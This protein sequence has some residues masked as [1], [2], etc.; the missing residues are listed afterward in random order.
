MA[1]RYKSHQANR[2]IM[3]LSVDGQVLGGSLNQ[4]VSPAGFRE[5]GFGTLRFATAGNHTVRLAMVGRDATAG[6]YTITADVFTLRPDNT[7]PVISASCSN[8]KKE[9]TG[10]DGAVVTFAATA[11]DDLDGSV[12]VTF[13]PPSGSL[14]ALGGT[15]IVGT[16]RDFMGNTAT[17]NCEVIVV[18]T[19][20]PTLTLSGNLI[21]E[22]TSSA[23]AAVT[24]AASAH[25]IV[26]GNVDVGL[27]HQSG[28][29]FPL[30]VT[31]V[32]A[33]AQD[34]FDNVATGSFTVTVVDTTPPTIHVP[35]PITVEATSAAGAAVTFVASA[36]DVVSG[37]VPVSYSIN[38]GSTFPLG[39]TIVTATATDA[40]GNTATG[41]FMVTV[42][43]STA[44]VIE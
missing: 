16:A 23:G 42:V 9:A 22:A 34:D 43:D 17:V 27:S 11:T 2:G 41:T 6:A 44:P 18:D 14:F 7:A 40:A 8:L 13:D 37:S 35:V 24:F 38:P 12:P 4:H 20:P 31:V 3:Q 28:S 30:G 25:D 19:T 26:S 10:P 33:T 15:P 1:L 39:A 32:T 21:V 29:I 5:V 36:T